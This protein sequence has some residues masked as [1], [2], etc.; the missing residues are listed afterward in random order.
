MLGYVLC[1]MVIRKSDGLARKGDVDANASV[2]YMP[3]FLDDRLITSAT[4][5][6]EL[7]SFSRSTTVGRFGFAKQGTPT[8]IELIIT[9]D[10]DYSGGN[11]CQ[12]RLYNVT[13]AVVVYTFPATAVPQVFLSSGDIKASLPAT[14]KTYRF[15]GINT[16]AAKSEELLYAILKITY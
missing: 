14:E 12:F 10:G 15:E 4:A 2:V 11:T 7:L 3:M 1:G 5:W 6:S 16:V 8:S 13:N 9:S